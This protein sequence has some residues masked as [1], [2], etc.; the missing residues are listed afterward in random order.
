MA[1]RKLRGKTAGS[2][3][4]PDDD[5]EAGHEPRPAS[6]YEPPTAT[7]LGPVEEATASPG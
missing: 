2:R 4:T 6:E 5:S 7:D 1:E 3:D